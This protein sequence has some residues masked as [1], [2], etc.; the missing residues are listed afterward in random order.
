MKLIYGKINPIELV[1]VF[2][3]KCFVDFRLHRT[4]NICLF[5]VLTG[6]NHYKAKLHQE[7]LSNSD[8]PNSLNVMFTNIPS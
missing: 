3:Y 2:I 5:H 6:I 1:H 7:S 4:I 8:G